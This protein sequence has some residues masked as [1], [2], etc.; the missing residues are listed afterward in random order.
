RIMDLNL[1][2]DINFVLQYLS[3]GLKA[4][5]PRN[6]LFVVSAINHAKRTMIRLI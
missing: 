3:N 4:E 5:H 2:I 6:W 1:F